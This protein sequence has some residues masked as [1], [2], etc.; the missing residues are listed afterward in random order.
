MPDFSKS[1]AW[2][3]WERCARLRGAQ[4]PPQKLETPPTFTERLERP[5]PCSTT[6]TTNPSSA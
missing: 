1:F 2:I 6:S 5:T 4:E 3:Q